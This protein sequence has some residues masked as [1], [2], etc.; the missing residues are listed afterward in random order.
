MGIIPWPFFIKLDKNLLFRIKASTIVE[1]K[2]Q[3]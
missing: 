1:V 3:I 2:L